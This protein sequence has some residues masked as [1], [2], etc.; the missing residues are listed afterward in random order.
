M[1]TVTG[2]S[3]D[4]FLFTAHI[5]RHDGSQVHHAGE[6]AGHDDT[7]FRRIRRKDHKVIVECAVLITGNRQ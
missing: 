7:V 1:I 6:R 5:R 4:L 3:C 2:N